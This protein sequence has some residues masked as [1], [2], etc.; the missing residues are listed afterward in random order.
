MKYN[1]K[2]GKKLNKFNLQYPSIQEQ[3]PGSTNHQLIINENSLTQKVSNTGLEIELL[4]KSSKYGV[5]KYDKENCSPVM[6]YET[7]ERMGTMSSYENAD[8]SDVHKSNKYDEQEEAINA[9]RMQLG[10]NASS[11]RCA[12]DF[13]VM[14][15]S[16]TNDKQHE[17]KVVSNVIDVQPKN[18]VH[19]T[20][21]QN[22]MDSVKQYLLWRGSNACNV[23][24][25]NV[26]GEYNQSKRLTTLPN[27]NEPVLDKHTTLINLNGLEIEHEDQNIKLS[28]LG[29][30]LKNT[31]D[32]DVA[33][34]NA[35]SDKFFE[36]STTQKEGSKRKKQDNVRSKSCI[37]NGLIQSAFES[38]SEA[39]NNGKE[40][41]SKNSDL[42]NNEMKST[43]ETV[44]KNKEKPEYLDE[45]TSS[46]LL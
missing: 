39:L 41:N 14:L 16:D 10:K 12:E 45:C 36:S 23:G 7:I 25:D 21:D 11:S 26:V 1:T 17:T 3:R 9:S 31:N 20:S 24:I 38:K 27:I 43:E 22:M 44:H 19:E 28:N 30:V 32:A 40:K 18:E 8:V 42:V 35:G 33:R 15:L 5:T 34:V 4:Y 2:C 13:Y 37:S 6:K 29:Y 46:N